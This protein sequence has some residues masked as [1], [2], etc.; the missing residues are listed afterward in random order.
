MFLLRAA[1]I[2]SLAEAA[3][4]LAPADAP[5]RGESYALL[6]GVQKYSEAKELRPLPYSERDVTELARL[7]RDSGY[8]ADNVV[9]MTQTAAN[10]DPRY[11]PMK[12]RILKELRLLLADRRE[13]DTVL[14]AFAGHGVHFSDDQN[15]YFCPA[16]AELRDR[17]TLL[18]LADVYAELEK[19][20]AGVKVLL[21]DACRNDPFQDVTRAARMDLES[22]T[23]PEMP[24]PPKGVIAFFSCSEKEKAYEDEDLHHGVFF[25]YVIEG[26]QGA[27]APAKGEV[28]LLALSE[29]VTRSVGDRVRAAYGQT[30]RPELMGRSSGSA[31]LVRLDEAAL[32]VRKGKTLLEKDQYDDAVDEFAQALAVNSR[33]AAAYAERG[34]IFV[35][36]GQWDKALEDA[37]RALE[38]EPEA[39]AGIRRRRHAPLEKRR[40]R[41]GCGRLRRGHSPGPWFAACVHL[42][43]QGL[44][45]QGRF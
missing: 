24:E 39:R 14:L 35:R 43:G 25:H 41:Q 4:N 28:T 33:C 32:H 27:A 38:V 9:L 8:K 45:G 3:P 11:T 37:Q 21:V 34:L 1:L 15:S 31:V 30:Q 17:D 42:P 20:R 6:V 7:L 13:D 16:D 40:F 18:S 23:R 22:V 29:Y 26:L 12:K 5:P 2:L 19:C 10:D 44:R 36:R